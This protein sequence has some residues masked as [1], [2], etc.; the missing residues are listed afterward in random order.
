LV[1]HWRS[2]GKV[3]PLSRGYPADASSQSNEGRAVVMMGPH[4]LGTLIPLQEPVAA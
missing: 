4:A 2:R 3:R 1:S